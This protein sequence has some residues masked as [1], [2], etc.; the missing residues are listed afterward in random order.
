MNLNSNLGPILDLSLSF[1]FFIFWFFLFS[2]FCKHSEATLSVERNM[3]VDDKP[4]LKLEYDLKP[5]L[6][7]KF[8]VFYFLVFFVFLF[9]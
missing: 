1:L 5:K 9:L 8:F 7:L 4:K 3:V 6:E 2:Y